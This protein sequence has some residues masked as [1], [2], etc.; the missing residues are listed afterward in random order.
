MSDYEIETSTDDE[1]SPSTEMR[2]QKAM[3]HAGVASRRV[4]EDLITKGRVK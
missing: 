3:A 1:E 4:C 2:L